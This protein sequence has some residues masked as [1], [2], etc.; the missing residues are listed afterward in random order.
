MASVSVCM[1]SSVTVTGG[2]KKSFQQVMNVKMVSETSTGFT[3]GTTTER[4]QPVFTAAV[5]AGGLDELVRHVDHELPHQ[6]HAERVQ[7]GQH[8]RD[9]GVHQPQVLMMVNT[10]MSVTCPGIINVAR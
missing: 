2:H 10:G 6:K 8:Q 4:E 1:R 3:K 9:V 7:D 5:N